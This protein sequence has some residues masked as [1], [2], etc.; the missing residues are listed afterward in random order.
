MPKPLL[1]QPFLLWLVS[2]MVLVIS[3]LLSLSLVH[4]LKAQ[5][6]Q[7][8]QAQLT[9]KA[10]QLGNFLQQ[11]LLRNLSIAYAIAGWLKA[12][13]YQT[14][15]F[16][17]LASALL[18]HYP[19]IAT[20]S[21]APDAIIQYVYPLT[22]N[23]ALLGYRV[24]DDPAQRDEALS[25]IQL[26][27]LNITGPYQLRQGGLGVVGRFP[28]MINNNDTDTP[29]FWGF[30]N[31]TLRLTELQS[32]N[33]LAQLPSSFQYRL[34]RQAKS[35][36]PAELITESSVKPDAATQH[37][38]QLGNVNWQLDLS[39]S[40]QQSLSF[41]YWRQL[42][43]ASLFSLLLATV[44]W[45]FMQSLYA[46]QHLERQVRR[47]TASLHTQLQRYRSLIAASNTGA[48]EYDAHSNTLTCSPEYFLML[49]Y[50]ADDFAHP[51]QNNL[52]NCWTDL[53]HPEDKIKAISSFEQYI[54]QPDESMYDN[55]FRM[56]HKQ[57][58]WVWIL[59][60]GR[61]LR[62]EQQQPTFFTVGTHIDITASKQAQLK[63]QLLARLFEQ[64]SEGLLITDADKNIVMVN[65][66]FTKISGYAATEVLGRNP[67]VLSSGHHDENFY[68]KMW[69]QLDHNG[70]WQGEVWNR[71]KDGIA[72]PE[73]LSISQIK[74]E[75]QQ[76]THYVA[77]FSD[78]SQYKADEAKIKFLAHYDPLT[79]LP[80]RSL[81]LDK[82]EQAIKE[83]EA[84]EK[85]L[86][87]LFMDLDRF[88][89][90][91]ESLGHKVG[92][93]LLIQ[94]ALRLQK[95]CREQDILSR[96]GGDEFVLVLP[97]ANEEMAEQLARRLLPNMLEPF[98]IAG[99][100][101]VLSVSVGIAIYPAHGQHFH[102]LYKH[103]DI[104]MYRAKEQG[105]NHFN[106]FTADMQQFHNRTLQLSNALRHAIERNELQLVYQPQCCLYSGSLTGFEALLRW[107]NAEL[108]FVSPA[109]FIPLAE[110]NGLIVAIGEWVMLSAIRQL[111][112]WH[113][114]GYSKLVMAINLSPIQF[115]QP[116]LQHYISHT[117][118][119]FQ[120]EA[121][122]VEL[123]IT[124]SA[125]V[126]QP[127]KAIELVQQLS[128]S[129]LHIAIDDFGT[130]YSSLSYLKRFAINK[131]KI[132][133]S[134]VRDLLTDSGDKAI[135]MA[136]ISMAQSLRLRT[137][138]EGVE[139]A[140]HQQLLHQLG[141]DEMQG[142]HYSRP[143]NAEDSLAFIRQHLTEQGNTNNPQ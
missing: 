95:L 27:Q 63:L 45:Q 56:R 26:K 114:A 98:Y 46:R 109:E 62:D 50:Q 106:F 16:T 58:H 48:W 47:R 84:A 35:G 89:E 117:L 125:M 24:L 53:L 137:I 130:G 107:H 104:A 71:R 43:L 52:D 51:E 119:Y 83:A 19:Q 1:R 81:L 118:E 72:Y 93:E 3:L 123:E 18:Q 4:H 90:I 103:A 73:W 65:Q 88:K 67:S 80:N 115:K 102:E 143:L 8:Q 36:F 142:Y 100:E 68:R 87:L 82:T 22:D 40:A 17:P 126:E 23:Q 64:S 32:F 38:I 141:C 28:I 128:N 129:G 44:C 34:S 121:S 91:N 41:M 2:A 139:T 10:A 101:L 57:G 5:R 112:Y 30:V 108:G 136:I 6:Q 116:N 69:Q 20:V 105:R 31:V 75:Q 79:Q 120:V 78:I 29:V 110:R 86:A 37:V 33:Q 9:E 122:K 66:A 138:A 140:A 61:T 55:Q 21:L 135:V 77:L 92:D 132:D 14:E 99:H 76:L 85:N 133:Q 11:D 96:L 49:G 131:L 134:F 39:S 42:A 74:D 7:Q 127:E 94:V 113:Q 70:S 15:Q 59:S 25:S 13:D 60:R 54:K 97:G 12:N 111:K 124:E